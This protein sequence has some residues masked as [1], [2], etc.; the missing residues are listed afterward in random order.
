MVCAVDPNGRTAYVIN[1]VDLGGDTRVRWGFRQN[2]NADFTSDD[3]AGGICMDLN[4]KGITVQYSAGDYHYCCASSHPYSSALPPFG[5]KVDIGQQLTFLMY[6][7]NPPQVTLLCM[8][9]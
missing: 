1:G 9:L 4:I 8:S 2:D 7:R 3:V 6:G 5:G